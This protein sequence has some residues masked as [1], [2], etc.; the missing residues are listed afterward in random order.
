MSA[1]LPF[2]TEYYGTMIQWFR[3]NMCSWIPNDDYGSERMHELY[4]LTE[5]SLGCGFYTNN[6]QVYELVATHC[7]EYGII[8]EIIEHELRSTHTPQSCELCLSTIE[9]VE[10]V[11]LNFGW[12]AVGLLAKGGCL[13][14]ATLGMTRFNENVLGD[15]FRKVDLWS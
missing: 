4:E 12:E 5:G 2:P 15:A 7:E 3:Y 8:Y 11:D 14:E 9:R 10:S 13:I 1:N 6:E